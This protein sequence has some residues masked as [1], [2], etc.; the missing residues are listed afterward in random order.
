M[1]DS[2]RGFLGPS[3]SYLKQFGTKAL[4]KARIKPRINANILVLEV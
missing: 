1:I 2:N 4:L 3:W